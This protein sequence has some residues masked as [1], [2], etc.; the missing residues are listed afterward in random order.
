[1]F[2]FY[3]P[4]PHSGKTEATKILCRL[5]AD[6]GIQAWDVAFADGLKA[7]LTAL[8]KQIG[9]SDQ[10][11]HHYLY[12]D[13]GKLE[14][15]P[16]LGKS[17]REAMTTL[18][19][20]WGRDMIRTD[21][22][23]DLTVRRAASLA[24][25]GVLPL[26]QDVRYKNEMAA[27]RRMGGLVFSVVRPGT[28]QFKGTHSSENDLN[29]AAFDGVLVNDGTLADLEQR[30]SVMVMPPLLARFGPGQKQSRAA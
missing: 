26:F 21:L 11:I 27:V 30:I 3:A 14:A 18:G 7:M 9:L 4:A 12:S 20:G 1:M 24:A 5:L 29:D 19:A 22:W 17:S 16:V 6:H 13:K 2:G 15:V 8:Y 10:Q 28:E 25:N 23:V